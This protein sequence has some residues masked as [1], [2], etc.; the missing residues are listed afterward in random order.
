MCRSTETVGRLLYYVH[1]MEGIWLHSR[2]Q[3]QANYI[4]L[5]QLHNGHSCLSVACGTYSKF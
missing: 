1:F 5:A 4:T 3:V 2:L